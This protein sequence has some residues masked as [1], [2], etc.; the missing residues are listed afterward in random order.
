MSD[1]NRKKYRKLSLES[2]FFSAIGMILLTIVCGTPGGTVRYMAREVYR[3]IMVIAGI[4][5]VIGAVGLVV[6]AMKS[7]DEES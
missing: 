7:E 6:T 5:F 3:V 2:M 4:I 1:E